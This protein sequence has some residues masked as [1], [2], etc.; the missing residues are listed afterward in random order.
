VK[1]VLALRPS[2]GF[3]IACAM[4]SAPARLRA[5]LLCG[6]GLRPLECACLRV[7]DVDPE[8]NQ[9]GGPESR[10]DLPL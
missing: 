9:I 8:R 5:F 7:K 4:P 1:S 3:S 2:Y 6:A 10:A